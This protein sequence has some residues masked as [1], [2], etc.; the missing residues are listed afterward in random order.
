MRKIAEL[1]FKKEYETNN[2]LALALK[3]LPLL[4]FEK[5]DEIGNSYDDI[6]EEFQVVCNRTLKESGKIAKV[7]EL[8]LYFGS[9]YIKSLVPRIPIPL[10]L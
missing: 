2:E 8:C 1:G 5:E 6:V 10:S 7:D 3:M 9:N 4:A